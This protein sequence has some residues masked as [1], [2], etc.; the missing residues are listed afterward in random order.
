MKVY[1]HIYNEHLCIEETPIISVEL[2]VAP[3]VGD[4]IWI[5]NEDV[6]ELEKQVKDT[7]SQEDVWI[8][9]EYIYC[10]T[11]IRLSNGEDYKSITKGDFCK[12]MS[13][14]CAI[15][16]VKRH[17]VTHDC[18]QAKRGLHVFI[19]KNNTIQ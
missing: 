9:R 8:W 19:H 6:E 18:S 12:D 16:V 3:M 1:I 15:Y 11:S 7:F 2:E 14:D 17:I 5:S 13:F 10:E 4:I